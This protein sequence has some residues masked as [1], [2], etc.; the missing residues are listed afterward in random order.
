MQIH[1]LTSADAA[2]SIWYD[3]VRDAFTSVYPGGPLFTEREMGVLME[4]NEDYAHVLW[5]AEQDGEPVGA[6]KLDLPLRDN[7]KLAEPSVWVRPHAQRRGIGTALLDKTVAEAHVRGRS[8]LIF[9]LEGPHTATT[10]S[11]T[12]F[13]ERSGFTH[14]L[15]E[16][17]RV[18]E[19]PFDLE[20]IA[21]AEASARVYATDYTVTTFSGPVPDKYAAE[22]ARLEGRLTTDAPLGELTYEGEAWDVARLRRTERI[23]ERMGRAYWH[24]VALAPDGTM[25]G[26]TRISLSHEPR[27]DAFQD[28][29]LVDPDHRGH[30]LGLLLKAANLRALLQDRPDVHTI[31]T[32]NAES[33]THMISV[34]E[35]LGYRVRGWIAEYQRDL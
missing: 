19:A 5:L 21:A 10:T 20:G 11:G 28:T 16:I 30:R 22:Y 27:A 29:T 33:N 25:A 31:W 17:A 6:A 15:Q 2:F 12:A 7:L 24:A 32:W 4:D 23:V 35:T 9:G 34:N 3:I 14:R 13:A 18:Q 1:R 26:V 8:I